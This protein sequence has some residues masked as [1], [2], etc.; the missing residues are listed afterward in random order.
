MWWKFSALLTLGTILVAG[1]LV[2]TFLVGHYQRV[3]FSI[4]VPDGSLQKFAS[5]GTGEINRRTLKAAA[6]TGNSPWRQ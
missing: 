4:A 3:V 5:L 1:A 2:P 6:G